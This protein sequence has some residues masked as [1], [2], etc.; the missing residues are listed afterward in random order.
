MFSENRKYVIGVDGGGTKTTVALADS[1]GKILKTVKVGSSSSRNIGIRKTAANIAEGIKKIF[2][3]KKKIEILSIFI[4]L[5][6]VEEEF[7]SRTGEIKRDILE[8]KELSLILK[9]RLT[10]G[11]DQLVAFR[12][13]TNS[14]DGVLLIAGTGCVAHGWRGKKEAKASGWGWLADE[15]SSFWVGQKVYQAVL[16]SLD[17]RGPKTQLAKLITKKGNII[18]LNKSIYSR[19]PNE[20]LSS[21]SLL[22]DKAARRGDKVARD[23]LMEA[24]RE[25]ALAVLTVIR[26]LNFQKVKFPLVLVGGVF[27]SDIVLPTFKREIK[28]VAPKAV[29]IRSK[30]DPVFGAVR[31]AL[32]QL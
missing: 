8:H 29:F 20:A 1:K 16:K 9:S 5:P 10:V 13:G 24:A 3:R 28:K 4:G 31:L 7:K 6:S 12:S 17:G 21:F 27:N 30:K 18:S 15:G 11:S 2:P 19:E 14:K 23:I 22:C 26:R 32:E 25:Q